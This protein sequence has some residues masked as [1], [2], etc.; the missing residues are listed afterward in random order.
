MSARL[1]KNV[2]DRLVNGYVLQKRKIGNAYKYNV[3]PAGFF[4][5]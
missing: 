2:L 4:S 1:E 5:R 3:K